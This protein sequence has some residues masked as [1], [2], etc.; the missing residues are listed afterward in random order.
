MDAMDMDRNDDHPAAPAPSA[1]PSPAVPSATT[2]AEQPLMGSSRTT[3]GFIRGHAYGNIPNHAD[4]TST[5]LKFEVPLKGEVFLYLTDEYPRDVKFEDLKGDSELVVMVKVV[6]SM[7]PILE[8]V[9]RKCSIIQS[10]YFF[11]FFFSIPF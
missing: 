1:P 8:V 9:A 6:G 10:E 11:L 4:I 3:G 5:P 2:T 7:G